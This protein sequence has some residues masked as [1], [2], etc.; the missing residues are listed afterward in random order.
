[1][2][3]SISSGSPWPQSRAERRSWQAN[4]FQ[5]QEK[6]QTEIGRASCGWKWSWDRAESNFW[7]FG[8]SGMCIYSNSIILYN[9]RIF[10]YWI[11]SINLYNMYPLILRNGNLNKILDRSVSWKKIA[12]SS[13]K[14]DVLLTSMGDG[15]HSHLRWPEVKL[16]P[17]QF[18]EI[19]ESRAWNCVMQTLPKSKILAFL[20]VLESDRLGLLATPEDDVTAGAAG[21]GCACG[22]V[23]IGCAC[24]LGWSS[25]IQLCKG[26]LAQIMWYLLFPSFFWVHGFSVQSANW[27][28]RESAASQHRS[29]QTIKRIPKVVRKWISRTSPVSLSEILL[30]KLDTNYLVTTYRPDSNHPWIPLGFQAWLPILCL[31][32]VAC[33]DV[34]TGPDHSTRFQSQGQA[35]HTRCT[36]RIRL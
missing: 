8:A 32:G 21:I 25:K 3:T 5:Q 2:M 10:M 23:I 12:K 28:K 17:S 20:L 13:R 27:I 18:G 11:Y 6:A 14:A 26:P 1:M 15:L 16:S 22:T 29:L 35:H 9:E 7:S 30:L 24:L 31:K 19:R 36:L 4:Q 34:E 33:S